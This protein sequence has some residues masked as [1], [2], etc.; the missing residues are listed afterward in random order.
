MMMRYDEFRVFSLSTKNPQKNMG[1]IAIHELGHGS[2]TWKRGVFW[3]IRRRKGRR[4]SERS[5]GDWNSACEC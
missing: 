2:D 4:N 1:M 5:S 3:L